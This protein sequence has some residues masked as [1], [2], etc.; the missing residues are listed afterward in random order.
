MTHRL[1]PNEYNNED[2]SPNALMIKI[3][4]VLVETKTNYM[5]KFEL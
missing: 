1:K 3:L 5:Y 2:R 4:A